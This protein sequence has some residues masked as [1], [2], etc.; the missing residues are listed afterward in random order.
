MKYIQMNDLIENKINNYFTFKSYAHVIAIEK[1]E[2][3]EDKCFVKLKIVLDYY[4]HDVNYHVIDI[5]FKDNSMNGFLDLTKIDG[6]K[7]ETAKELLV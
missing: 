3:R 1:G 7:T 2:V 4:I 6:Y 5:N